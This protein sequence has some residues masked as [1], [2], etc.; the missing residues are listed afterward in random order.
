MHN[1]FR[2]SDWSGR[3]R[4][5]IFR[6]ARR[7]LRKLKDDCAQGTYIRLGTEYGGWVIDKAIAEATI[8]PDSII[9]SAGAGEDISFDIDLHRLY[10]CHVVIVDPTP[11]AMAHFESLRSATIAGS[12][13]PIN[14]SERFYDMS[15]VDLAKLHFVPAALWSELTTIKFWEPR[16]GNVSYSALNIQ[17]TADFIEVPTTTVNDLLQ[18]YGKESLP[19]LKLDIEGAEVETLQAMLLDTIRPHQIAVEF[20]FIH[21]PGPKTGGL[22]HSIIQH[23]R[24]SGYELAHYDDLRSCLFRL[25]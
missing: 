18:R 23:L 8:T 12:K 10:G 11:R 15:D 9:I 4:R 21:R 24:K 25:R 13:Y 7:Y 20:D 17:G 16:A 6:G 14:S 1:I 19:L 3:V 2:A 22:L 5:L